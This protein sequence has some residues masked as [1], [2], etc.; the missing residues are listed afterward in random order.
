M[1]NRRKGRKIYTYRA[2]NRRMF[3]QY[4]PIRSALAVTFFLI[5]LAFLVLVGYGVSASVVKRLRAE[6]ESPTT[7]SEPF[8]VA[9][10]TTADTEQKADI[11]VNTTD[12]DTSTTSTTTAVTSDTTAETTTADSVSEPQMLGCYLNANVVSNLEKLAAAAE[13]AKSDGYSAVIIPLKLEGGSLQFHSSVEAA[14]ECKASS[15]KLPTLQDIAFTVLSEGV[16]PIARIETFSDNLLPK[17]FEDAA[18]IN[19]LTQKPWLDDAEKS[20]G[21]PWLSPFSETAQQYLAEICLEIQT[22]GFQQIIC[23]GMNYPNFSPTDSEAIGDCISNAESRKNGI[24]DL[25]NAMEDAADGCIYEVDL[26]DITSNSDDIPAISKMQ[27]ER[28]IISIDFKDFD[29]RF[30]YGGKRYDVSRLAYSDKAQLLLQIA[31]DITGDRSVLPC[32]QRDSLS[33]AQYE[34]VMQT[35][36]QLGYNTIYLR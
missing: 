26:H 4:H 3:S 23:G 6:R 22:A 27:V 2:K 13:S 18:F 5:L 21:K 15:E 33:D 16:S 25:F 34:T 30:Y 14:A 17:K 7:T 19:T 11:N 20:G 32:I 1:S 12:S 35:L 9:E 29:S 28:V 36:T 24:L 8:E 31:E 10:I